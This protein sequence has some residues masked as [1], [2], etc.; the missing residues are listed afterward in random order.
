MAVTLGLI[1]TTME[2]KRWLKRLFLGPLVSLPSFLADGLAA[3]HAPVPVRCD[4]PVKDYK[5]LFAV[6]RPG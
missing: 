1:P 3:Y 2:G 6:A 4:G 5:I